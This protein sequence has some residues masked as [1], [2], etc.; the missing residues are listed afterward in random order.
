MYR[1]ISNVLSVEDIVVRA[2]GFIAY[3]KFLLP[4]NRV[5]L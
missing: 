1:Q 2:N 4:L 3:V 5:N